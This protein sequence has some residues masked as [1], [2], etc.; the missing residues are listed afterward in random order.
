MNFVNIF[1]LFVANICW[2]GPCHISIE[3]IKM[4]KN[5]IK[6]NYLFLKMFKFFNIV[7]WNELGILDRDGHRKRCSKL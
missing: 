1:F 2:F 4:G 7:S 3:V 5:L 6:K